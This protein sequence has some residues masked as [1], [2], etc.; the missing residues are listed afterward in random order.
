[1]PKYTKKEEAKDLV[2]LLLP[3]KRSNTVGELTE[4]CIHFGLSFEI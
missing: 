2:C 1:M 3:E 4:L